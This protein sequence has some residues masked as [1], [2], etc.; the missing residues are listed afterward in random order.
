MQPSS[1]NAAGDAA[2]RRVSIPASMGKYRIVRLIGSGG[3]GEILLG[4]DP[5]GNE[6]AI[7]ILGL[8][9]MM[10]QSNLQRFIQEGRTLAML[11]HRNICRVYGIEEWEGK[12]YIVMEYVQG[13]SL[14]Q[15]L[16]YLSDPSSGGVSPEKG[17]EDLETIIDEVEKAAGPVGE[18]EAYMIPQPPPAKLLPLQ[19]A[20]KIAIRLCE[21]VQYAHERGVFHRDIKPSNVIV[22]RDGEPVLL[23]F[24]LAKLPREPRLESLTLSGQVFGTVEYMA[25]EQ[26]LS[27]RDV[28]ERA[29]VFSLGAILYEL[30]T[31]RKHFP[32]SGNPL[33]DIRRLETYEP[34]SPR[35][36]SRHVDRDLQAVILKALNP[37][38]TQ[39][40]RFAK[41]LGQELT[42]YQEGLPVLAS[43]PSAVYRLRKFV[44]RHAVP[45]VLSTIIL[46]LLVAFGGYYTWDY[47]RRW[48]DWVLSYRMDFTEG[49]YPR[50]DF[51]FTHEW[52]DNPQPWTAGG[53]GL[54]IRGDGWCWLKDVAVSGNVKVVA[55]IRYEQ[56]ADGFELA[57]N[58][59]RDPLDEWYHVPRGYSCQVGG[60]LGTLDFVSVNKTPGMARTTDPVPSRFD[61]GKEVE[62]TLQRV[63]ET[64]T[65][66][67]NGRKQA[68]EHDNQPF[69][70]PDFSRIGFHGYA[71]EAYLRSIAVYRMSLPR[72]PSPLIAGDALASA[73]HGE[74]A[75]ATYLSI[76]RDNHSSPLGRK[77]LVRALISAYR[78]DTPKRGTIVDSVM[79]LFERHFA[80]SLVRR[81]IREIQLVNQWKKRQ[82]DTVLQQLPRHFRRYPGTRIALELQ[83]IGG[84]DFAPDSV[85]IA[86]LEWA[87]RTEGV[88]CLRAGGMSQRALDRARG[89]DVTHVD[90]AGGSIASLKPLASSR[91]RWLLCTR[92]QIAS[93]RPLRGQPI[94]FLDC[95]ENPLGTLQGLE[96]APLRILNAKATGIS[97]ISALA[98]APLQYLNIDHAD[99][100]DLSSLRN[101]NIE[102]L[103]A[104]SNRLV[105]LE[106]LEGMPLR[107][108]A[109]DGNLIRSLDGLAGAPLRMLTCSR[110]RIESLTPLK[111]MPLEE[112]DI[113]D[114]GVRSLD[115][116]S[117]CPL[118]RLNCNGNGI[119]DLRPLRGLPLRH[120]SFR[121]NEV[122]DLQPL[123]GMSLRTLDCA[124]NRIA[125]LS[126]VKDMPVRH[127]G[128]GGNP[129]LDLSQ[130]SGMSLTSLRCTR[131]GLRDIAALTSLDLQWLD[132]SHNTIA[133]LSPL[134]TMPLNELHCSGNRIRSLEPLASVNI[135]SLVC[136]NNRIES[137]EPLRGK[138]LWHLDCQNNPISSLEPFVDDPPGTFFFFSRSIPP[139]ELDRVI[140]AWDADPRYA[141]HQRNAMILRAILTER[142]ERLRQ[143]AT[144]T[145]G[146][147]YLF[148]P[149]ALPRAD[150]VEICR[151]AGGYLLRT[152]GSRERTLMWLLGLSYWSPWVEPKPGLR[153]KV[154]GTA[155]ERPADG[156]AGTRHEEYWVLRKGRVEAVDAGGA[157][158]FVIQWD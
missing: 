20:L 3:M 11:Q 18:Q 117:S 41:Q 9:G 71:R 17:N 64:V 76:A 121:N 137:L 12:P 53:K 33:Q 52:Q 2:Q 7:K 149:W 40:Y 79:S 51:E 150:A 16:R 132:C 122:R 87:V 78:L 88:R 1:D 65:L 62:V 111:D 60:Y 93:L 136:R 37:D 127:L 140:A 68:A 114:N 5:Y 124:G 34:A 59:A 146:L 86:L 21:A 134:A 92:N 138:G 109:V 6:V 31:G 98:D 156:A 151:R 129:E 144:D 148:V 154:G 55:R 91:L 38:R 157:G 108:L 22:R 112:L 126:P 72:K 141:R 29:D 125:D 32:S 23:D 131:M 116:L 120:L 85:R 24:G 80:R 103:D 99:V 81:D 25:P 107:T 35:A 73:G 39:R 77:A 143:M 47:Y 42:R 90:C 155:T 97:D 56:M 46:I 104:A 8:A 95:S 30:V 128:C 105:S 4:E 110:N 83:S 15:L 82:F 19:Q 119:S 58:C 49:E 100:A 106:P 101:K 69:W 61:R 67:V 94:A 75:I 142:W 152:A 27:T 13:V 43:P 115:P 57:I 153:R 14:A 45:V 66:F 10:S 158:S 28:D 54:T 84:S 130:L 145:C 118:R 123:R 102:H 63:D 48:G 70:G 133:D 89:T 96:G 147:T 36:E 44:G 113:A 50:G 26:A 135:R 74:D 139:V